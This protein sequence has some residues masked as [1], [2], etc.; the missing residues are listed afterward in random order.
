MSITLHVKS[1]H[2]FNE[3]LSEWLSQVYLKINEYYG[4]KHKNIFLGMKKPELYWSA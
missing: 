2:N 3:G 1:I 4:Y